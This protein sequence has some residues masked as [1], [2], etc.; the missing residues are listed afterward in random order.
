MRLRSLG[1]CAAFAVVPFAA[2]AQQADAAKSCEPQGMFA[3]APTYKTVEV[4][5]D[6]RVTFRICAPHAS[7]V[8]VT[9]NDIDEAIP[10]GFAP[11]SVRGLVMSKDDTGL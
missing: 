5:P 10:M 6:S 7:E 9:S 11:G 3:P 4:L 2:Q 8:K 1:L